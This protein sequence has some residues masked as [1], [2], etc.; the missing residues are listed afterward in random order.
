MFVTLGSGNK[1]GGYITAWRERL[2]IAV[3][4]VKPSWTGTGAI[5]KKSIAEDPI[6]G[7]GP[8]NFIK[9]WVKYKPDGINQTPYWNIDFRYG[10]G[11]IPTMAVETGVLG[12]LAWL[13]LL[14]SIVWYGVKFIFSLKQDKST[15]ALLILA[16]SGSVYLWLFAIIYPPDAALLALAFLVTGLFSAILA[17]TKIIKNKIIEITEDPRVNFISVLGFVILIIGAIT[18]GYLVV[19]KYGSYFLYQKGLAGFSRGD[20]SLASVAVAQAV[21]LSSQDVYHRTLAELNIASIAR[22]LAEEDKPPEELRAQFLNYLS[23]AMASARQAIDADRTDYLNWLS[24][25]R[26]CEAVVPFGLENAYEEGIRAFSEAKKLNPKNPSI[27]LSL[28]CHLCISSC[29]VV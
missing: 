15:R 13:A 12:I 20:I 25:G 14:G 21:N 7:A 4:E 28:E 8:N 19:Q 11:F 16:F 26:V 3:M 10:V 18:G 6:F 22:L 1:F 17:D 23:Q 29:A 27:L 2:G 5:M 9:E 24:L